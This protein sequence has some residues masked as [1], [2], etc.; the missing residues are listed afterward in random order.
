[1]SVLRKQ[2]IAWVGVSTIGS[3][4]LKLV[5]SKIGTPDA[6]FHF[7]KKLCNQELSDFFTD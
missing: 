5:L 6:S 2:L 3:L 1:M 7:V 4:S